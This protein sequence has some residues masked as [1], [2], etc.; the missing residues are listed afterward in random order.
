MIEVQIE[1][2]ARLRLQLPRRALRA[3]G[4]LGSTRRAFEN[5]G[6]RQVLL[7]RLAGGAP[8]ERN[9]S[10]LN[11]A[12]LVLASAHEVASVPASPMTHHGGTR[13]TFTSC[14]WL[15]R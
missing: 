2:N 7:E 10:K 3:W 11:D 15:V 13:W 8:R 1:S 5:G 9:D 4:F 12:L 6:A 14:P